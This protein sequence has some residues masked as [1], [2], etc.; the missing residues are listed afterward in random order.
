MAA[1]IH[2]ELGRNKKMISTTHFKTVFMCQVQMLQAQ[3]EKRDL[4][5]YLSH[6]QK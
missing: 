4:F 5:I 3:T 6:T 1:R 2:R